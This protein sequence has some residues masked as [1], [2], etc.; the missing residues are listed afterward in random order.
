MLDDKALPAY[1]RLIKQGSL[2]Q[3]LIKEENFAEMIARSRQ[4]DDSLE[5]D[6]AINDQVKLTVQRNQDQLFVQT[7]LMQLSASFEPTSS[8]IDSSYDSI[9]LIFQTILDSIK[10][11]SNEFDHINAQTI[12][13]KQLTKDIDKLLINFKNIRIPKQLPRHLA[14]DRS[15]S[16]PDDLLDASVLGAVIYQAN[17]VERTTATVADNPVI[18]GDDKIDDNQTSAL[19]EFQKLIMID[20]KNGRLDR[21]L[22]VSNLV[23]RDE[24]IRLYSATNYDYYESFAPFG[25]PVE[26]VTAIFETGPIWIHCQNEKYS[27]QLPNGFYFNF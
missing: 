5:I 7:K 26:N 11:L 22:E 19:S 14:Q 18:A 12:D 20:S 10:L 24:I 15:D 1:N 3:N 16:N 27:V 8:A 17:T 25:R 6:Q 9:Y 23:T 13:V 2:I 21:N 4:G